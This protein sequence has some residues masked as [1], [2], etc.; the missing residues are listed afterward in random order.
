MVCYDLFFIII[1]Y[2]LLLEFRLWFMIFLLSKLLIT[3]TITTFSVD[4]PSETRSRDAY[5]L[6][7]RRR[8]GIKARMPYLSIGRINSLI[9]SVEIHFPTRPIWIKTWNRFGLLLNWYVITLFG[10]RS[11]YESSS[12]NGSSNWIGPT[13]FSHW[14]DPKPAQNLVKLS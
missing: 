10:L 11:G 4:L 8:W 7:E 1:I 14:I 9:G 5:D 2:D 3:H 12:T 13:P 6:E